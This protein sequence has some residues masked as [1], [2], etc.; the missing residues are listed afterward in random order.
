MINWVDVV[1]VRVEVGKDELNVLV[2]DH[3]FAL[4]CIADNVVFAL[5]WVWIFED[6]PLK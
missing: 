3:T 4:L 2:D 6:A 1:G 5:I